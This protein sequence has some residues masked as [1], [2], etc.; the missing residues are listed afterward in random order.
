MWRWFAIFYSVQAKELGQIS[1]DPDSGHF[2]DSY[3]RVRIFHGVNA[4]LKESP[5]LPQSDQF[6]GDDSL[7]SKTLDF[8]QAWHEN[9]QVDESYVKRVGQLSAD[10]AQR[11]IYTIAD[12]H[13]DLGS[14]RFCGEGFPEGYVEELLQDPASQMSKAPK[15]P[16]PF[17]DLPRNASGFPE[18]GRCL[19]RQFSEYYSTYQVGAL[20]SELYRAGSKLQEGFLRFWSAVSAEFKDAPHLLAYELLNEPSGTCLKAHDAFGCRLSGQAMPLRFDN[21]VEAYYLTPLYQA[22]ARVIRSNNAKQVIFYEGTVW[23]KIGVDVFPEPALGADRQQALA[24][25]IYCDGDNWPAGLLCDAAQQIF[26]RTYYPFLHKHSMPGFMTEFG[27]VKGNHNEMK[28]ISNLLHTADKHFQSWTYWQL[29]KFHDFTTA[30]SAEAIFTS[31]GKI[32]VNKLSALS[33]LSDGIVGIVGSFCDLMLCNDGIVEHSDVS[34]WDK[35]VLKSFQAPVQPAGPELKDD[36][37]E[38]PRPEPRPSTALKSPRSSFLLWDDDLPKG[39][40]C[41]PNRS[42]HEYGRGT[43]AQAIA[44]KPLRMEYDCSKRTFTLDFVATVKDAP[45]EIYLNEELHYPTGYGFSASPPGCLSVHEKRRNYLHLMLASERCI[46]AVIEIRIIPSDMNVVCY[47]DGESGEDPKCIAYDM[48]KDPISYFEREV[49]RHVQAHKRLLEMSVAHGEPYRLYGEAVAAM[50][51]RTQSIGEK[52][53]KWLGGIEDHFSHGGSKDFSTRPIDRLQQ[54]RALAL[55]LRILRFLVEGED[56]D[57]VRSVDI[58]RL[59]HQMTGDLIRQLLKP[60]RLLQIY[61]QQLLSKKGQEV[62]SV[63]DILNELLVTILEPGLTRAAAGRRL[64]PQEMDLQLLLV[65]SLKDLYMK[66]SPGSKEDLELADKESDE[67]YLNSIEELP[68]LR[69]PIGAKLLYFLQLARQK[70]LAVLEM[71]PIEEAQEWHICADLNGLCHCGKGLVRLAVGADNG[72]IAVSSVRA[73]ATATNC[74]EETF[75]ATWPNMLFLDQKPA[76]KDQELENLWANMEAL[77]KLARAYAF[78]WKVSICYN[79][80]SWKSHAEAT[81]EIQELFVTIPTGPTLVLNVISYVALVLVLNW[82]AGFSEEYKRFIALYS[83]LPTFVMGLCYYYYI[84]RQN[85]WQ[86]TLSTVLGW[87]NNFA[88]AMAISMVSFTQLIFRYF[89]LLLLEGVL[90]AEW[91]GYITFPLS[92]IESS[93]QNTMLILY[94]LG[95]VLLVSCPLWCEGYRVVQEALGRDTKLSR[96]EAVME[97]LYTT[98][99]LGVVLQLQT[100]LAMIQVR[101]GFH[102]HF[103]HF[104]AVIVEH[105][106]FHYMVQ[107]KFAWL[108]KLYHEIQP[109]YRLVHLEHHICKGTYPTTPAAGLWE[110]WMEGGTLFFCNTL[111]CVPYFF[112]HAA[113]SGPNVVVHNMWPHKSCIQ[114]HTLHH[115]VH[116]DVYAVNV[117]SDND[118]KFSRD[119]KQYRER[120]QCS[121]FIRYGFVSDLAGF[122]MTFVVGF[123]LHYYGIGLFH[124]W[125]ER[126]LHFVA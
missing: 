112:F 78:S 31:D 39:V 126:S 119:V 91:Q 74:L 117:P 23:P 72:T 56:V 100:A 44:G 120:L 103:I 79:T 49:E 41:A 110:V 28:H 80:K 88:M 55:L 63:D 36:C 51:D 12:L 65:S 33:R 118:E 108:H 9:C 32:E 58:S 73:V 109:L 15:F 115:V 57:S 38:I 3:G 34:V 77:D 95:L 11:G 40:P 10:L 2:V 43:Y 16:H 113:S 121:P 4:V 92:T 35:M 7:D 90:P 111:A 18:L 64:S 54:Q 86:F 125:N 114:W 94:A 104:V 97:I 68:V 124:V 22:A 102:F 25:H 106:F 85:M 42:M 59:S 93:V 14:R 53:V 46:G 27:A 122:A 61:R 21:R 69:E 50:L 71:V 82:L 70:T 84:F 105:I 98:S 26:E 20:F 96:S 13:Q 47:D 75:Q 6:T 17:P 123:A 8:L 81:K 45:T 76:L 101:L 24:Y 30:N 52:L 60:K 62:L 66:T 107:F 37:P 48:S 116:S 5:W 1:V 99:Q 89:S 67:L 83:L 87:F 19:D 29:K